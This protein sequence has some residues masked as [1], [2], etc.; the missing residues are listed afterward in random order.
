M[1]MQR[2][3]QNDA[4]LS[5][6]KGSTKETSSRL[7]PNSSLFEFAG[8][9]SLEFI[10]AGPWLLDLKSWLEQMMDA[11]EANKEMYFS[12]FPP[13]IESLSKYLK[14][15]ALNAENQILFLISDRFGNLYGH[16]GLKVDNDGIAEIDNVL[17]IS[18]DLPGIM[19]IAIAEIMVWGV[20]SLGISKYFL[21]VISTNTRAIS[22]YN[23]LGFALRERISLKLE[24]LPNGSVNLLQ[25]DLEDSNTKEEMFIFEKYAKPLL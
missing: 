18:K 24:L 5:K 4:G 21:K 11:R 2:V 19:K 15:G 12:R 13:S 10:V 22:L 9:L 7:F 17:R 8:D 23:N 3:G 25:S 6:F 14:D 16:V 20:N 1:E